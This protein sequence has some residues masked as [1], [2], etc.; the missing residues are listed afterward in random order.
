VDL[1]EVDVVDAHPAQAGLA[2]GDQVM[3]G[4]AGVVRPGAH[5]HAG[6]G[7][8]QD[9]VAAFPDRRAEDLLRHAA[10]V[11]VGRVDEVD[12]AVE[13]H[14]DLADGAGDVG[15]AHEREPVAAAEGHR[16][17]GERGDAQAGVAKLAVVHASDV[18]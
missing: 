6:L 18:Y 16:A 4:E 11:H 8:D 5:R 1:E 12:A 2:A 3:A 10:G 7:G 9:A 17:Q 14:V 13:A 15:V